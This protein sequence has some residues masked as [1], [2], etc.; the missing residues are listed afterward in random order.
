LLIPPNPKVAFQP[1]THGGKKHFVTGN[2]R[3]ASTARDLMD[4]HACEDLAAG[5]WMLAYQLEGGE[6]DEWWAWFEY[7]Y[8]IDDQ[9]QGNIKL[10]IEGQQ[11]YTCPVC[12]RNN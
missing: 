7:K 9:N 2:I 8:Q 4:Q 3:F 1:I 5:P 11:M 12:H 10:L 6:V